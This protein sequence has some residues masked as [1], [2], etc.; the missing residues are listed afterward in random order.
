MPVWSHGHDLV[1][2][3]LQGS[4]LA[5]AVGGVRAGGSTLPPYPL[6][7]PRLLAPPPSEISARTVGGHKPQTSAGTTLLSLFILSHSNQTSRA[8]HTMFSDLCRACVPS[9]GQP[10]TAQTGWRVLYSDW[11]AGGLSN[12]GRGGARESRVNRES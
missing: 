10:G 4:S 7:R 12:P 8:K 9:G 1:T 3:S 6:P 2:V 5:S 11:Y